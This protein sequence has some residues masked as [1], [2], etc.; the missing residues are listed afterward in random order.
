MKKTLRVLMAMLAILTCATG[1]AQNFTLGPEV[2]YTH[3]SYALNNKQMSSSGSNGFR[4][5]ANATYEFS[6][7]L[8][9]QSGLYYDYNSGGGLNN[10]GTAK[11][12]HPYIKAVELKKSEFIT[13]PL[14]VG[15]EFQLPSNFGIGIEAG[16]Y[17]ATAIGGGSSHFQMTNGEANGGSLFDKSSF[18][19]FNKDTNTRDKVEIN[20][21]DR[22]DSGFIFGG[23]IRYHNIR[24]RAAYQLGLARTIYDIAKPRTLTLT[25]IYDFKL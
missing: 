15:Y 1:Y 6:N 7:R 11:D 20:G 21:S 22:I 19:Y 25:L 10:I 13:L 24:L 8:F 14:E 3:S 9:L 4:I 23:H 17:I 18:T 2:G 5:G 16:G 12:F